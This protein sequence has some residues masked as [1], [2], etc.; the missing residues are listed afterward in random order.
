MPEV[1][2]QDSRGMRVEGWDWILLWP[3]GEGEMR[4]VSLR[5]P[6][7]SLPLEIPIR[8]TDSTSWLLSFS[9]SLCISVCTLALLCFHFL[10]PARRLQ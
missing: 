2:R 6:S 3:D 9:I 1:A 7:L 8:S 4:A 5:P 10:P